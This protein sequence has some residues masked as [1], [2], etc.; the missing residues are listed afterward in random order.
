MITLYGFGPHFGL[1]DPSPFVLKTMVQL[2]MAGLPYRLET[3]ALPRAPKGKLPF[4]E[5]EGRVVADSTFIRAHIEQVAGLDLD[6]GLSPTERAQAWAVERMVED[7]L[8][9]ALVHARWM[10]DETFAKGPAQFFAGAPEAVRDEVMT[11]ARAKV[12]AVLTGQGLGRHTR[13]E[14]LELAARSMDALSALIGDKPFLFGA[15]PCG[16]DAVAFGVIAAALAPGLETPLRD[17]AEQKPNLGR[18]RDRMMIRFLPE[19]AVR[20]LAP[21]LSIA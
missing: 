9:W 4:I 16:A 7:H 15:E 13:R 1:P 20:A 10:D 6:Q 2:A 19:H 18:Y 8:Y 14:I 3:G 17:L 12:A 5:H 11:Q 21:V